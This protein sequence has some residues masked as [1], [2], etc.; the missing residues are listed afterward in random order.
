MRKILRFRLFGNPQIYLDDEPVFFAFS[1]I[2]ALLYYLAVNPVISRDE[3]AGLLWPNKSEQSAKKNLRNTIYQANKVLQE[4]YIVSPN[5]S[6]LQLNETLVVNSDAATFMADPENN[7]DEYQDGFLKGFFLKDSDNF[8]LWSTKMNNFYAQKFMQS[9]YQKVIKDIANGELN[10]VEKNI[11]R[12]ISLD[13]YD[14]RN[15]QLLMQFY[16]DQNSSGKVIEAYYELSNILDEELGIQ[17][18]DETR[19]IYEKTL[20]IVNSAK[21]KRK[22]EDD[23]R[24]FGRTREIETLEA[25]FDCYLTAKSFKSAVI[26]GEQGVG[27]TALCNLLL[28]NLQDKISVIHATCFQ[29]EEQFLLRPW[30]DILNQLSELLDEY[31]LVEPTEWRNLYQQFFPSYDKKDT[32]K[33]RH[34]FGTEQLNLLSQLILEALNSLKGRCHPVIYVENLQWMDDASLLLLTSVLLHESTALFI[35]PLRNGYR[36]EVLNFLNAVSH[37]D[38]LLVMDL[39]PFETDQVQAFVERQLPNQQFEHCLIKTLAEESE[40]NPLFLMEYVKQIRHNQKLNFMTPKIKAELE[41]FLI[42]ISVFQERILHMISFFP[43]TASVHMVQELLQTDDQSIVDGIFDLEEKG[44]LEE[45]VIDG[46]IHVKFKHNKLR[47]YVYDSQSP[48]KLRTIHEKIA[49]MYERYLDD[50]TSQDELLSTIAYHYELANQELKSLDYELSYLQ[51][52]LKFQHELFP[53]YNETSGGIVELQP[54]EY[55]HEFERFQRIGKKMKELGEQYEGNNEYEQLLMKYLYLE[56]RYLI[57][58]GNYDQGINRIQRVIVKAKERHNDTYLV[59]GYRQMIYYLI[60]TDNAT[61]MSHYIELA[62]NVSVRTNDHESIG[63]LLRLKGLYNLMIGNLEEAEELSRESITIFSISDNIKEKYSSNIAAAYDYL[64]EIQRLKENYP[65]AVIYQKKAIKLCEELGLNNSLV[66]FY[67]DMG[68]SQ[69]AERDYE[70]AQ[71][72]FNKAKKLYANLT[73]PWKRTQ[74]GVYQSLIDLNCDNLSG[75][76]DYFVGLNGSFESITNPRDMGLV[77]FLRAIVRHLL[78]IGRIENETLEK[79]LNQSSEF[80]YEKANDNLNRYRD[81]YELRY[82]DE[83]FTEI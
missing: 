30:R 15:Y 20:A 38:K 58:R 57:N 28:N 43:N 27:K 79:M 67:V 45:H 55:E 59:K 6:I 8:D 65:Q 18:S 36:R 75:V 48:S 4:D 54:I 81:R 12:L 51:I 78:D 76:I 9:C 64:A 50:K 7:L 74:L 71:V 22:K 73:S 82:L 69:F 5:K 19:A 17:P 37:Y 56:G 60:Q 66:I 32:S 34:E 80:Y 68:V 49:R 35:L 40:G 39:V 13:E 14:E 83:I 21:E 33:L 1:K 11:R 2:N 77:Y 44:I 41:F 52:A 23:F 25:N 70:A 63:I 46:E 61:D 31:N 26:R 16:Q 29:A 3:I 10:D 42:D 72:Y 62:M 24:F 47:E 53:I